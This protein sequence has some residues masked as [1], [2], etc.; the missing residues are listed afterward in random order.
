MA[1][2]RCLED[3][4]EYH[5][6]AKVNRGEMIFKQA[7]ARALFMV[8]LAE[9]KLY[10]DFQIRAFCLMSNHVHFI[11][12]PLENNSLS[13]IMQWILSNFAMRYNKRLGIHGHVWQGRFFSKILRTIKHFRDAIEYVLNNPVKAKLVKDHRQWKYCGLWSKLRRLLRTFIPPVT[14]RTRR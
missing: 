2:K 6:S 7:F 12:K 10:Y 4:A 8:V 5:V 9:A 14:H 13:D 1:Y 3:G 11:M